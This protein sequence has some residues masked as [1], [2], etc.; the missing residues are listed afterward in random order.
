MIRLIVIFS[1]LPL[2][3]CATMLGQQAKKAKSK[4]CSV[5]GKKLT[6]C[7]GQHVFDQ[8]KVRFFTNNIR[9]IWPLMSKKLFVEQGLEAKFEPG[10]TPL[11]DFFTMM[12]NVARA[13]IAKKN[14]KNLAIKARSAKKNSEDL[15][16]ALVKATAAG[17]D[18][19]NLTKKAKL[20]DK[21]ATEM[22][23]KAIDVAKATVDLFA[24]VN[25]TAQ[26][27][28]TSTV[29]DFKETVQ[30]SIRLW[31]IHRGKTT[32][33]VVLFMRPGNHATPINFRQAVG[34]LYSNSSP[35][36]EWKANG[37]KRL[38][39]LVVGGSKVKCSAVIGDGC[40]CYPLIGRSKGSD[41]LFFKFVNA[42]PS[43]RECDVNNG[44]IEKWDSS[45]S[46]GVVLK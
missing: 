32:D 8:D 29:V 13:E 7:H 12:G 10:Y 25:A 30:V 21:E 19:A 1:I 31:N 22:A 42:K 6:D 43:M 16:K 36:D 38:P 11:V 27:V 41:K 35:L 15:T 24:I 39:Y 33:E 40:Y 44:L 5:C 18:V 9:T 34:W 2:F 26:T 17:L 3:S 46:I 37:S 14:A 28:D 45:M 4:I 20:A 23:V